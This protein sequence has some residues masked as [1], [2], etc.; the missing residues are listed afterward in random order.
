[1]KLKNKIL[2]IMMAVAATMSFVSI[3]AFAAEPSV[4]LKT[5]TATVEA[6]DTITVSV[7]IANNP[8]VCSAILAL[9]SDTELKLTGVTNGAVWSGA[10]FDSDYK[11]P[12]MLAWFIDDT[13]STNNTSNGVVAT[14]T[15][16]VSEE[17]KAGKYSIN[18][19]CDS[20]NTNNTD[21]DYI[22][23]GTATLD[24]TVEGSGSGSTV[25]AVAGKEIENGYKTFSA[26]AP[27][28]MTTGTDCAIVVTKSDSDRALRH[29]L[30]GGVVG[31]KTKILP[32][33]SYKINENGVVAGDIFTITVTSGETTVQTITY[34]VP[35]E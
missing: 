14:L 13:F 5:D 22:D 34:T 7:D 28:T 2:S 25:T 35:A 18:I 17:A 10:T 11:N 33:V 19:V 3:S 4:S 29:E 15:Y 32:I 21:F 16:K 23:F 24:I 1:M 6:G 12:Y 8:G 26:S 9:S 27:V 30:P 31:G 20:E